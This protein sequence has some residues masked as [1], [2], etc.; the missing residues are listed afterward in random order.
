MITYIKLLIFIGVLV[1]YSSA[2]YSDAKRCYEYAEGLDVILEVNERPLEGL[3]G[4]DL[5]VAKEVSSFI[6]AA[7]SNNTKKILGH[8]S[9]F[10][11][12]RLSIAGQLQKTP[13]KFSD[14][15]SIKDHKIGREALVWGQNYF[16]DVKY[17]LPDDSIT[18][19]EIVFCTNSCLMSNLY[20]DTD[21]EPFVDI[22]SRL[23]YLK[24]KG[25]L[26]GVNCPT[27]EV[28]GYSVVTVHPIH[29][30]KKQYPVS[31]YLRKDN[32]SKKKRELESPSQLLSNVGQECLE[33]ISDDTKMQELLPN[34]ISK[35]VKTCT[36]NTS[37]SDLFPVNF[38]DD[39]GGVEKRYL[40]LWSYLSRVN[41][42]K[43]ASMIAHFPIS[44]SIKLYVVEAMFS[45]SEKALIILPVHELSD[46]RKLL[47][48]SVFS[49]KLGELLTSEEVS[50]Y[51]FRMPT[52]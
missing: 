9:P 48:W 38:T 11:G 41:K 32:I 18:I 39:E 22:I 40:T 36:I 4:G 51:F 50:K 45:P 20:D 42:V 23:I 37:E 34:T 15:P 31:I 21:R 17:Q 16:I 14:Y 28:E 35:I 24:R 7:K 52:S 26:V 10:D 27:T 33:L 6:E 44:D 3:D 19:P 5:E 8:F 25:D 2:A 30:F 49:T 12:S 43:R 29:S 47:D 1:G 46:G 13:D